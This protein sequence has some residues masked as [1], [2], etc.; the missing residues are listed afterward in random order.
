MSRINTWPQTNIVSTRFETQETPPHLKGASK[1][2]P[3]DVST[4]AES[5]PVTLLKKPAAVDDNT[6]D[7]GL[8]DPSPRTAPPRPGLT[9]KRS[10]KSSQEDFSSEESVNS[11][12]RIPQAKAQGVIDGQKPNIKKQDAAEEPKSSSPTQLERSGSGSETTSENLA[13]AKTGQ[14]LQVRHMDGASP[15]HRSL[16]SSSKVVAT[17]RDKYPDNEDETSLEPL[18]SKPKIRLGAVGGDQTVPNPDISSVVSSSRAMATQPLKSKAR[19]GMIGGK[20]RAT[21]PDAKL[22]NEYPS[23]GVTAPPPPEPNPPLGMIGKK[24]G[25]IPEDTTKMSPTRSGRGGK[26]G[27]IGGRGKDQMMAAHRSSRKADGNEEVDNPQLTKWEGR[28]SALPSPPPR[29]VEATPPAPETE[30]EKANRR[31]DELKRQ[32]DASSKAPAKKKRKF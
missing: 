23:P 32:L 20:K 13:S 16:K 25:V 8:G 10:H 29:P 1:R 18:P 24:K 22:P 12:K 17:S 11:R 21:N 5:S 15:E 28:P 14:L 9:T 4:A 27:L 6:T 3:R 31:R 26:L 19:L 30:E 2:Q 7:D